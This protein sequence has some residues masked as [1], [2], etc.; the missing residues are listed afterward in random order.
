M[1][2]I[3]DINN[4]LVKPFDELDIKEGD[5][6]IEVNGIEID[7][8]ENLQDKVNNSKGE[9]I[10]LTLIRNGTLLTANIK[11]AQTE[12]DEYK[13]GLWVKDAATGVGTITFYEPE[14]KSFAALGHGITDSDTDKLIDIDSG[15]IVTSKVIDIKKSEE[16]EAGEIKGSIAGQNTIG[17]VIKNTEFGIYGELTNLTSL[18]I[19]TSKRMKV[20]LRNEIKVGEAIMKCTLDDGMCRDYKIQ[21]EKVYLDNNSNNKSMLIKII[22]DKLLE[23]TG[24]IVRGLSGAPIIQEGKFVGAVTNVLVNEPNRGYA[25]F[26]E[27]M[28]KELLNE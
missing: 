19:D 15:E 10:D 25:V 26:A 27:I 28:I 22:D 21:I 24:G 7:S 12:E 1:S 4:S 6:I 5:T 2:E 20:A 14:S 16:G 9:N 17:E 13:L 8:I 3:E 18:N 11:P 23:K